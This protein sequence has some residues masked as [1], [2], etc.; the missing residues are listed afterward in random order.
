MTTKPKKPR[1]A[2]CPIC[3]KRPKVT[4]LTHSWVGCCQWGEHDLFIIRPTTKEAIAAWNAFAARV[5]PARKVS[6]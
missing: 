5:K 6:K 1:I 3:G 4:W 2:R